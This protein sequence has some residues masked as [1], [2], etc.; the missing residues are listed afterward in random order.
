MLSVIRIFSLR[1]NK[2]IKQQQQ[3]YYTEKLNIY[4]AKEKVF[5]K[6][7]NIL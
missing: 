4:Q 2:K 1:L 6:K 3:T 7:L 5:R